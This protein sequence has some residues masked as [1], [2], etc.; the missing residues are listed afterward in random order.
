ML[1][2]YTWQP[3]INV[4][5]I[6]SVCSSW[7]SHCTHVMHRPCGARLT[8][9]ASQPIRESWPW[10]SWLRSHMLLTSQTS[11]ASSL[12]AQSCM[13]P[14]SHTQHCSECSSEYFLFFLF[15][16]ILVEDPPGAAA[17]PGSKGKLYRLLPHP[18]TGQW[19]E[20]K[21]ERDPDQQL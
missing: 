20:S 16:C 5:F 17:L 8:R 3:S 2:L 4:S 14:F 6:F 19:A 18:H 1:L 15:T 11:T 12:Y 10:T 9:A 7:L 13:Q 21:Q